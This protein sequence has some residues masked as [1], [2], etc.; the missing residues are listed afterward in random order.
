[1]PP[2]VRY[3]R[4]AVTKYTAT[5]NTAFRDAGIG[6][7]TAATI[8][9]TKV[10]PGVA[11]GVGALATVGAIFSATLGHWDVAKGLGAA[12][13][14]VALGT[15]ARVAVFGAP[16]MSPITRLATLDH[17]AHPS[18]SGPNT[19]V[20]VPAGFDPAKPFDL[21][22]YFRGWNSCVPVIAGAQPA[23]C[24]AGGRERQNSDVVGQLDRAGR[25]QTIL[26]MPEWPIEA[27][28]S[29]PGA[30]AQRGAF[31]AL[32]EE[33]L[34]EIVS[35]SVGASVRLQGAKATL[36]ASHSGGYNPTSVA[37]DVGD[38]PRVTDIL[39]LDALYGA[40]ASFIRFVRGGGRLVSIFTS[41]QT[42]EH[43]LAVARA[44]DGVVD[45]SAEAPTSEQWR[46]K[47]LA[48]KTSFAHS[49]VPLHYLQPWLASR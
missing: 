43:S 39:L 18:Q 49:L 42:R 40:D 33:V 19:L 46:A 14:G 41:G 6:A 35:P 26:I 15:V 17:A 1:M 27:A 23:T 8:A 34:A 20:H 10:T 45:E 3:R 28:S 47:M 38:L 5:M 25:P 30:L 9:A 21:L 13:V 11:A 48:K 4:E 24:S 36:I 7:A 29:D 22:F 2:T 31:R 44:V 37:V 16:T 32:A 12:V